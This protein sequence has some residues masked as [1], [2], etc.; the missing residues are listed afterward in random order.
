MPKYFDRFS[1]AVPTAFA[2]ALGL[3]RFEQGDALYDTRDAYQPTWG[4]S[5]KYISWGIEVLSPKRSE[6]RIAGGAKVERDDE[7]TETKSS[8]IFNNNWKSQLELRL[9][10]YRVNR[11]E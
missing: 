9:V 2:D 6:I 7:D 5:L 1:W 8:D 3:C 10:D 11:V 4:E